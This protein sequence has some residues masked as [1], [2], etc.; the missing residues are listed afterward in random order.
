MLNA[1]DQ[2]ASSRME[3]QSFCV[4]DNAPFCVLKDRESCRYYPVAVHLYPKKGEKDRLYNP[5]FRWTSIETMYFS[6]TSEVARNGTRFL[7]ME[8]PAEPL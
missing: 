3:V 8:K 1:Q 7:G 2:F 6:N 4:P 5:I